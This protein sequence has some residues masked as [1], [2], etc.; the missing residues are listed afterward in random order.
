MIYTK[1]PSFAEMD[2]DTEQFEVFDA[3]VTYIIEVLQD[4]SGRAA[5]C[6]SVIYLHI[7]I[8]SMHFKFSEI[9][10]QQVLGLNKCYYH[11]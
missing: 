6:F 10:C 9:S 11:L 3:I 7:Q 5:H 4:D 1:Q 2:N 8:P